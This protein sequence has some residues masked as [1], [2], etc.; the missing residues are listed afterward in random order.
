MT[1]ESTLATLL[2]VFAGFGLAY[3]VLLA[4]R[5]LIGLLFVAVVALVYL[6]YRILS[7]AERAADA[8]QRLAAAREREAGESRF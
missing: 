6:S 7:V 5:P 4:G 2:A 3:S 1:D 8:L